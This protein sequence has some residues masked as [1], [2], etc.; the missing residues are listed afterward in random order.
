MQG[1]CDGLEFKASLEK[2]FNFIKLKMSLNCFLEKEWKVLK[3]LEI[4]LCETFNKSWRLWEHPAIVAIKRVEEL[5]RPLII[6]KRPARML[7]ISVFFFSS[8][9]SRVV[10]YRMIDWKKAL[11]WPWIIEWKG[12]EKP[13]IFLGLLVQEPC[14]WDE[15]FCSNRTDVSYHLRTDPRPDT[16][17]VTNSPGHIQLTL[18]IALQC[19]RKT[20]MLAAQ[21]SPFCFFMQCKITVKK[22]FLLRGNLAKSDLDRDQK[23]KPAVLH[24]TVADQTELFRWTFTRNWIFG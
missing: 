2:S 13:W 18:T 3:S 10:C 24:H 22:W 5:L 23:K 17:A 15:T 11:N 4:C 8:S 19:C 6:N 7:Q 20:A 1:S 16:L 14:R 9:T 12:L 21:A